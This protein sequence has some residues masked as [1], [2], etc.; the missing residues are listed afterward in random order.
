M[1]GQKKA[2]KLRQNPTRFRT[3]T[4]EKTEKTTKDHY[5]GPLNILT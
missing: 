3:H 1:R 2:G 5:Q 4:E